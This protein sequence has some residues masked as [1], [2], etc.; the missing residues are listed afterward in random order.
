[1]YDFVTGIKKWFTGFYK[2]LDSVAK[3]LLQNKAVLL[4]WACKV[5]VETYTGSVN[6]VDLHLELGESIVQFSSRWLLHQL[7]VYLNSYMLYKCTHKKFGIMLYRKGIDVLL[8]LS[9]ALGSQE[10]TVHNRSE[11]TAKQISSVKQP[12]NS[13]LCP[14]YC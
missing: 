13:H 7:I 10:A 14:V 9:W 6:M 11:P 2:L 3:H 8:S 4:P 1:M 5:F 12:V